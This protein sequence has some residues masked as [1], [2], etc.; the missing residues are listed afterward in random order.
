MRGLT[1]HNYTT[2]NRIGSK[3]T[4]YVGYGMSKQAVETDKAKVSVND[5]FKDS[6]SFDHVLSKEFEEFQ[7]NHP[8]IELSYEEY[9]KA[10]ASSRGFEY[11]SIGDVQRI[12]NYGGIFW[13]EQA[14]S[15]SP[16]LRTGRSHGGRRLR[17]SQ[18]RERG[19]RKDWMTQRE[20][21]TGERFERGVFGALDIIPGAA[22]AKGSFKSAATIGQ[23][24][25]KQNIWYNL[26]KTAKHLG[27]PHEGEWAESSR[28]AQRR[29]LRH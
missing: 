8:D 4:T 7:I 19:N 1:I 11:E 22:A 12:R 20:L 15:C 21:N 6:E 23:I 24:S 27:E 26:L 5:I 28:P 13:P 14:L 29:R 10:I 18:Y 2:V 3:E 17:R 25:S 16:S 9:T